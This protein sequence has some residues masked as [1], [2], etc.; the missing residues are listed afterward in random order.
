[1]AAGI[2]KPYSGKE[3]YIFVSYAHKDK[4]QVMPIL[5]MLGRQGFRVWYDEGIDPGTEW[6]DYIAEHVC[7]CGCMVAF[8]S[9]NY[10]ASDNCRDE[11]NFARDLQKERLLVYLEDTTLP[12][13][14]AMRLNR[15]QAIY[16]Y[17]YSPE[18][19]EEK[20]CGT[21]ILQTCRGMLTQ[22]ETVPEPEETAGELFAQGERE[23]RVQN[24]PEAAILFEKAADR[25]Y[26]PAQ[27]ALAG[28]YATGRGVSRDA[29]KVFFWYE[30]AA[31]Q[32]MAKAQNALGD[33][34]RNGKGV[35]Q[36]EAQAFA[37]YEKAALQGYADAKSALGAC[38][39]QGRGVA[40]D[41]DLAMEWY[42]KA[43]R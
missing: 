16:S 43:I 34:Y 36:D 14:M 37:W 26:A 8:M 1:M 4:Q 7:S 13:G 40:Q 27:C 41:H 28:C 38:Y 15:L 24:Y 30:R 39:E 35:A 42:Q 5:Q 25:G 9:G 23:Y 31:N 32:G 11:L 29:S 22:E 2:P 18:E 33:L 10:V 6:D 20:L 3:P 19:F 17:V 12:M 21:G